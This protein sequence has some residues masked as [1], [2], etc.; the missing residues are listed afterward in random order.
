MISQVD[1]EVSFSFCSVYYAPKGGTFQR[2][3]SD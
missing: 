3:T 1:W 2:V